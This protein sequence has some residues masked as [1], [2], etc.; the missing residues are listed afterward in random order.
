M[1]NNDGRS[2][3]QA[4]L[5]Q[6]LA[7]DIV[8]AAW[9]VAD[10]GT[11]ARLRPFIDGQLCKPPYVAF[12]IPI[13]GGTRTLVALKRPG[14]ETAPSQ[15]LSLCDDKN[16]VVAELARWTNHIVPFAPAALVAGLDGP[17]LVQVARMILESCRTAFRLQDNRNF[18]ETCV[19]LAQS[20]SPRQGR[21]EACADI[22]E[23]LALAEG[24]LTRGFGEV[25][26]VVVI[27]KT[28]VRR[29]AFAPLVGKPPAKGELVPFHVVLDRGMADSDAVAVLLGAG[30]LA[31]RQIRPSAGA[32]V[33]LLEWIERNPNFPA[34]SRDYVA[35][36]LAGQ[37]GEEV[38]SA[39][40]VREMQL[41]NPLQRRQLLSPAKPVGA[42][43][44]MAIAHGAG[45]LF[46]KGWVRDPHQMVDSIVALSPFGPG[47]KLDQTFFHHPRPDVAKQY[48]QSPHTTDD[49]K[50]GFV[51]YLPGA[52]DPLPN[53]QQRFELQLKSGARVELVAPLQPVNFA[54]ARAAV[55]GS[56]PNQY[57]TPELLQT[58]IA[59]P[60]VALHKAYMA[61][62]T[63]PEV[64][65]LGVTPLKPAVSVV[66]P[67]YRNL[68][69]LR[70]QFGAFA[71]DPAFREVDLI[72]VLD[73]PEQRAEL[74]HFLMGL[75]GLYGLP[76]RLAVM[77]ANYG[78][79]AASNAG[80]ALARAKHIAFVNSDIVPDRPGWLVALRTAL[81]ASA[82]I[83]VVGPKLLFED[84]SLQHAGLYFGRDLKGQWFN[85]H[86]FKGYPRDFAPANVARAVPGVTGAVLMIKRDVYEKIG[87]FSEDFVIGDYED[88]DLCLKIRK[89]G[90][91]IRYVPQAEL[92]HFERRSIQQHAGYMR[93][94]ASE[95][96]R[97]THATRWGGFIDEVMKSFDAPVKEKPA[98]VTVSAT[99][100]V[101]KPVIAK[102]EPARSAPPKVEIPAAPVAAPAPAAPVAAPVVETAKE[103]P[104][105]VAAEASPVRSNM[106]P[107]SVEALI[108]S[109]LADLESK[110]AKEPVPAAEAFLEPEPIAEVPT[111]K[112]TAPVE[113]KPRLIETLPAT[114]MPVTAPVEPAAR[115]ARSGGNS[116]LR[117][118]GGKG[119]AA[120]G[121]E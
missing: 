66:I 95:L 56:V 10:P 45:G 64:I 33:A 118:F 17:G 24:G 46:V 63:A 50:L 84:D 121:A 90:L 3:L 103:S 78:Y 22:G 94:V 60:A 44:D 14:S 109:F 117:R 85:H 30:S 4:P 15:T 11:P 81:E 99:V 61:T 75:H 12:N 119:R 83:G 72:Y 97:L 53:Y 13:S 87:G 69:F 96:N 32:R 2:A 101:E 40:L 6:E 9:D 92:Y 106:D 100:H 79:A 68:D 86:Y 67:L 89:A 38:Q 104:A 71:V 1:F 28:W 49:A 82:D 116:F 52:A 43:I 115:A 39:A 98:S 29:N 91:Q 16:N 74:E 76:L 36:C 102:A 27:G 31:C 80:A 113:A 55:L 19:A 5:I 111:P 48:R 65:E 110:P 51:T 59:P 73:S 70:F 77:P 25:T 107:A 54:E 21:I 105:P 20:L 47:R 41:F 58:C 114:P 18:A 93:G 120:G 35:K 8:L 62:K 34:A 108:E 112:A 88:S 37:K 57:L 23:K 26:S 42:R 7:E